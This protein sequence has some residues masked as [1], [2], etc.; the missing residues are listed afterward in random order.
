VSYTDEAFWQDVLD[1]RGLTDAYTL[2]N[3]GFGV[4][5]ADGKIVSSIKARNNVPGLGR[6]RYF[7]VD[8]DG[9]SGMEPDRCF[10]CLNKTK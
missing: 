7:P 10:P 9:R 1:F 3:A 8:G 6:G 5:W 2:L 4:T